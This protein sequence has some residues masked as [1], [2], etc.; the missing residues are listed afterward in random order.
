MKDIGLNHKS[1]CL[2]ITHDM[3]LYDISGSSSEPNST[4]QK[5]HHAF[6]PW[7]QQKLPPASLTRATT[8]PPLR[9]ALL[10]VAET[11]LVEEKFCFLPLLFLEKLVFYP[12]S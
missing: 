11:L 10:Y 8:L 3:E 7:L 1:K 5:Q 9:N 2:H 6:P 4:L 12:V